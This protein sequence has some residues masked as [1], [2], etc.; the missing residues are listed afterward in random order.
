MIADRFLARPALARAGSSA[1]ARPLLLTPAVIGFYLSFR[2]IIVLIVVRLFVVEPQVGAATSLAIDF[3]LLVVVAFQSF[4]QSVQSIRSMMQRPVSRWVALYLAYA[5]CS[6]A[7]SG[8]VSLPTSFLYWCGVVADVALVVLML[9]GEQIEDV[10]HS[11][12]KGFIA[13]TCLLAV[14]A[15]LMPSQ[16]DLRLGD[17]EFFNTNQ[18]GNLCAFAVLLAQYLVS[19][20]DGR[21]GVPAAFLTLTV[22]RSLSKTTLVAFLLS[23]ALFLL[24]DKAMSRRVKALIFAAVLIAG[25]SFWGLYESYYDVYTNA[26]NQAETLT[27]RTAIWAYALTAAMEKPWFGNGFD[28]LWK[29]MPPFGPDQFEARHAENELLQQFFAYG[30]VGVCM[31]VGIYGSFYRGIRKLPRETPRLVLTTLLLFIGI[32]GFAEAEPFDLLLPLWAVVL[33]SA[34]VAL[35]S[36]H[37]SQSTQSI[38]GTPSLRPARSG[39]L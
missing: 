38:E 22:V 30:I 21:W 26:G 7:W 33:F 35:P 27:G 32:R 29:V 10:A 18:I 3:L 39:A 14:V 4:G 23:E 9:R 34:L 15:W 13:S 37:S 11:L 12:M 28:A 25:L 5:G 20:R 6:F 16:D 2:T 19:R 8:A 17:P 1:A 31:L 36:D 24:R